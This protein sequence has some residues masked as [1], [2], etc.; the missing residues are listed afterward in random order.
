[1][2]D[3]MISVEVWTRFG[4]KVERNFGMR[5]IISLFC[6]LPVVGPRVCR[7]ARPTTGAA[8]RPLRTP[9]PE[10]LSAGV[11]TS[12]VPVFPIAA[13]GISVAAIGKTG[14]TL[15]FTGTTDRLSGCPPGHSATPPST[16]SVRNAP[17]ATAVGWCV[18]STTAQR[19][20]KASRRRESSRLADH[21]AGK[22]HALQ[23]PAAQLGHQAMAELSDTA[24]LKYPVGVRQLPS[25]ERAPEGLTTIQAR[26]Y[27]LAY[28]DGKLSVDA[29]ILGLIAHDKAATALHR[30]ATGTHQAEHEAHE[31]RLATAVGAG[32]QQ[33]VARR[34]VEVDVR[35]HRAAAVTGRHAAETKQKRRVKAHR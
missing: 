18:T 28:R 23:L 2:T 9:W 27:N 25:G 20:C 31:R 15:V 33:A 35:Q 30:T 24:F 6:V 29:L 13:T 12:V 1:M 8:I 22:Q 5:G 11:F 16:C 10:S 7:T 26:E 17:P 32:Q 34:H 19:R 21:G 14:T 4:A 3:F